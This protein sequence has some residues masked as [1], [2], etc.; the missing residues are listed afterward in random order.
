MTVKKTSNSKIVDTERK[1]VNY[2]KWNGVLLFWGFKAL[3][4]KSGGDNQ[5]FKWCPPRFIL[6]RGDGSVYN[7]PLAED[8]HSWFFYDS[9]LNS[10]TS[11]E[12]GHLIK[13]NPCDPLLPSS[14]KQ[15]VW[16]VVIYFPRLVCLTTVK[17]VTL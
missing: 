5:P 2:D 1:M 16:A 12:G 8:C 7:R 6:C 3:S 14:Q 9:S 13:I 10:L 15:L 11:N 17:G 4:R